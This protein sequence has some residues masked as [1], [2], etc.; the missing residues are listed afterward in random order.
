M[1][2]VTSPFSTV[3]VVSPSPTPNAPRF[4]LDP[5]LIAIGCAVAGSR[6]RLSATTMASEVGSTMTPSV[7]LSPPYT[8]VF[9]WM[10]PRLAARRRW[11]EPPAKWR[12][13]P[14]GGFPG[15]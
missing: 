4:G 13:S 1:S 15:S 12:P 3:V 14:R 8:N 10:M 6:A 2:G 7:P 11:R 5:R 9:P